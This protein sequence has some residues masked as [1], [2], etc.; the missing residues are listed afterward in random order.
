[1]PDR[2]IQTVDQARD[3]IGK[4]EALRQEYANL[5]GRSIIDD[6]FAVG[7]IEYLAEV[8]EVTDEAHAIREFLGSDESPSIFGD[9]RWAEA[10]WYAFTDEVRDGIERLGLLVDI[11]EDVDA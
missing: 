4:F 9:D 2:D 1:M 3:L 7:R 8:D 6:A 5:I 11:E 10:G